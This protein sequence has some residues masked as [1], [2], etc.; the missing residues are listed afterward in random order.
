MVEAHERFA[1]ELTRAGIEYVVV[2][3][4]GCFSDLA[5]FL[6]MAQS[7]RV[8]MIGSGDTRINPIHGQDLAAFC[9]N[10]TE[11]YSGVLEVGGPETL[12][13]GEIAETAFRAIDRPPRVSR[14]PL[15]AART[16]L[17]LF[18]LVDR[19]RRDLAKFF[20]E[21]AALDF[22]AP[23]YGSRRL[24]EHSRALVTGGSG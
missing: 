8:W 16:G 18:G 1:N 24:A 11:E 3:P 20:V 21:S 9:A 4:T 5:A 6:S 19:N 23:A 13:Q 12:T 22:V 15:P 10:A 7:G 14:I 2:R 17:A